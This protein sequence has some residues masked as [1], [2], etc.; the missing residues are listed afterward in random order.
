MPPSP[1]GPWGLQHTRP[2][3]FPTATLPG[4]PAAA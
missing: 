1:T 3:R 2:T 4:D